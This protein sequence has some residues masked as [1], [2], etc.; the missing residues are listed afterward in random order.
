M[1]SENEPPTSQGGQEDDGKRLTADE[2]DKL[3]P[4]PF[5]F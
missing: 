2:L 1:A 5:G 3:Y 4:K